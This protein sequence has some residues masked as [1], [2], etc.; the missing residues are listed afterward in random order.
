MKTSNVLKRTKKYVAKGVYGTHDTSVY[1]CH[2]LELA[3]SSGR[4]GLSD[5]HEVRD[6]VQERLGKCNSLEQWLRWQGIQR[7]SYGPKSIKEYCIKV[8]AT[9]H[10][11][12]DSMIAE[13]Q[14]KGD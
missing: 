14:A 7:P 2:A 5:C 4:I 8:Q 9:R 6:I 10:A 3:Y 12:I 11:W 1:I 13:F